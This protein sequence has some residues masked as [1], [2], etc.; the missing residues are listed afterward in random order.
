M[1][2]LL[3]LKFFP[4]FPYSYHSELL[5]ALFMNILA[6]GVELRLPLFYFVQ[7]VINF[8][9]YFAATA[10]IPEACRGKK[11]CSWL[12]FF[13]FS[14][15]TDAFSTWSCNML[16]LHHFMSCIA[17]N[18]YACAPWELKPFA[19]QQEMRSSSLYVQVMKKKTHNKPP[20]KS[21]FSFICLPLSLRCL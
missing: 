2:K 9:S 1:Q 19:S 17:T 4:F 6:M 8:V 18:D 14:L 21:G 13:C 7:W 16:T 20:G 5:C 11:Q 12:I 3:T 15:K 10:A